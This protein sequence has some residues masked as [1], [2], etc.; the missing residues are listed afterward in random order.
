M[1]RITTL[2][3]KKFINFEDIY[4]ENEDP[5]KEQFLYYEESD[6][7]AYSPYSL[8]EFKMDIKKALLFFQDPIYNIEIS[9]H[10]ISTKLMALK[11]IITTYND[12]PSFCCIIFVQKRVT[13]ILIQIFL[14]ACAMDF[15]KCG[16]LI[17]HGVTGNPHGSSVVMKSALMRISDQK[18][19]IQEFKEGVLNCLVST[20]VGEEGLDIQ[21]CNLIIRY[22]PAETLINYIQSRGR[23]RHETSHYINLCQ[24]SHP[25]ELQKVLDLQAEEV[26]M[27]SLIREENTEAF[28]HA[29]T[30]ISLRED[31]VFTVPKT[32]AQCTIHTSI[33]Y[34]H[35]FCAHLPRYN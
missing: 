10:T 25:G 4:T 6:H 20:R 27:K 33:Q 35:R 32:G 22:D 17:G 24:Q 29:G 18:R 16:Y 14:N 30:S 34:L 28:N 8:D 23:A 26:N 13:A 3:S 21:P 7:P 11:N 9:E 2:L 12:D 5:L 31:E 19:A 1:N 15:L